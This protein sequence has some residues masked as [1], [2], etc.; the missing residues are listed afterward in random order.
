[1]PVAASKAEAVEDDEFFFVLLVGLL[2]AFLRGRQN[3]EQR[4]IFLFY[5]SRLVVEVQKKT[6]RD[7]C[8]EREGNTDCASHVVITGFSL[9]NKFLIHFG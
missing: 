6:R 8:I 3:L 7:I 1:M 9:L 2:P 5:F 4:S